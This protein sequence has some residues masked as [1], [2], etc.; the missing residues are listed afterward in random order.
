MMN[1]ENY[2]LN[3]L[4]EFGTVKTFKIVARST[5]CTIEF[6][7]Q[8]RITGIEVYYEWRDNLYNI[9][10]IFPNNDRIF[11]TKYKLYK[12]YV[13]KR[14]KLSRE[15]RDLIKHM[16]VLFSF[17]VENESIL[18]NKEDFMEILFKSKE[19]YKNIII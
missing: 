13:R 9:Q 16:D 10:V 5:Y 12:K 4:S 8:N 17:L 19:G 1:L 11:L 14:L 3:R 2:F 7:L 6:K 15:K 18:A